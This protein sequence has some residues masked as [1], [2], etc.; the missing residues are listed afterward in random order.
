MDEVWNVLKT[1]FAVWLT[2]ALLRYQLSDFD[3]WIKVFSGY[4]S[5]YLLSSQAFDSRFK[6]KASTNCLSSSWFPFNLTSI[7]FIQ[8]S[9]NFF[10]HPNIDW[11]AN[12]QWISIIRQIFK[13]IHSISFPKLK[14]SKQAKKQN[15]NFYSTKHKKALRWISQFIIPPV[16]CDEF[17]ELIIPTKVS[18]SSPPLSNSH[19]TPLFIVCPRKCHSVGIFSLSHQPK[20]NL[21]AKLDGKVRLM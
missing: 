11:T 10:K 1:Q 18:P 19:A 13:T 14:I 8:A 9:S 3:F 5:S 21:M 17:I 20:L 6:S 7:I 12:F 2:I 15:K 16:V 4:D